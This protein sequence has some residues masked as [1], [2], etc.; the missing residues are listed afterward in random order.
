MHVLVSKELKALQR[1]YQIQGIEARLHGFTTEEISRVTTFLDNYAGTRAILLP[2]RIPGYKNWDVKLVPTQ[3]TKNSVWLEY[4]HAHA[5]L[6][7]R[8]ASYRSFCHL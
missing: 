3:M 1:S 5:T 7:V 8:I 4:N 6:T 2:G